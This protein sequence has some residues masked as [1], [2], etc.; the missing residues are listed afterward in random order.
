MWPLPFLP[1]SSPF[2]FLPFGS[3]FTSLHFSCPPESCLWLPLPSLGQKTCAV[4]PHPEA[5]SKGFKKPWFGNIS[6]WT[7]LSGSYVYR[8]CI[9]VGIISD[10]R[11]LTPIEDVWLVCKHVLCKRLMHALILVSWSQFW[12]CEGLTSLHLCIISPPQKY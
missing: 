1:L 2:S 10:Q 5:V 3:P 9:V 4:P 6:P 8:I 7:V 11:W 12:G